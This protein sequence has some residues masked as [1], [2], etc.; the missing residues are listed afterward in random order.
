RRPA[1]GRRAQETGETSSRLAALVS[2]CCE[3]SKGSPASGGPSESGHDSVNTA[4]DNPRSPSSLLRA[5]RGRG[6]RDQRLS[7]RSPG[8]DRRARPVGAQ[9][10]ALAE[11]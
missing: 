9:A 11:G 6:N 5:A 1:E 4:D 2:S 8:L 3:A 7:L 10:Q